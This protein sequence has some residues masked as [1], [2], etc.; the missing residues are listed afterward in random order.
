LKLATDVEQVRPSEV[1]RSRWESMQDGCEQSCP[2]RKGRLESKL[3]VV[4]WLDSR[5]WTC[6]ERLNQRST[7]RLFVAMMERWE[8]LR[9]F[10]FLGFGKA[11]R[12][13]TRVVS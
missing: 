2:G 9:N 3:T 6:S 12:N 7:E 8:G 1:D 5:S 13:G 11:K 10:A 4:F